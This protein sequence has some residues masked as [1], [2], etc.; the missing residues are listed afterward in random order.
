MKGF[1]RFG[2]HMDY[3]VREIIGV[4]VVLGELVVFVV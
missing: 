4:R 3:C 2:L 1:D